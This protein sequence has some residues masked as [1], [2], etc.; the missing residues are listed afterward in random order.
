MKIKQKKKLSAATLI[1]HLVSLISHPDIPSIRL[2]CR[3]SPS[4]AAMEG[5]DAIIE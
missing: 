5:M 4:E 3:I 1:I 2:S